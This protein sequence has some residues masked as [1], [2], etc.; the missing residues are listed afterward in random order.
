MGTAAAAG[1]CWPAIAATGARTTSA[2][3]R[4]EPITAELA[5]PGKQ[6]AKELTLTEEEAPAEEVRIAIGDRRR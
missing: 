3:E 5:G 1:G 4:P 6:T 2:N